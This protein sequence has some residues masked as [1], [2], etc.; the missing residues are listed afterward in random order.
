VTIAVVSDAPRSALVGRAR[1]RE[2]IAGALE[3]LPARPGAIV[4]IE[5]EPGI[6]KSR[7]LDHLTARAAADGATVL[8]ARASEFEGD[9]PYALWTEALDRHL[10][11]AGE[12][13]VSRMGLADPGALAALLPA[14]A[15][16]GAAQPAPGDRH[17]AHRAL[18]DLLERLAAVRPLVVWMDDVHWA[19]PASLDALAALVR[20]PPAAPVLFAV[21]A[22]E[23]QIPAGLALALAG[24]YREERVIAL[25]LAPLNETEAAELVGEAAAAIFPHSGGNPFYLEQLARV[26]DAPRVAAG[27]ADDTVPPAVAAAL[28]AELAELSPQ[29]RR[30]LDAAAVAGDPFEPELAA[31]VAELP[32]PAA[33]HALDELLVGALVRPAGV[34]RR[35]AFRHPVVRHAVYVATPPGW[36]LGAHARAAEVLERR[37]AGPVQRAHHVEHA[38]RPGDDD[39]IALLSTAATE[40]QS[41]APRTAARFHAAALRLLGDHPGQ[42]ERRSR[43]QR[44]LADAQ[45]AGGDPVAARRTL[46]DALQ[47]AGPGERLALTV[48]LANQEWWLGGHE[49]AR[50]RLQV[51]LGELPAQASPDRVRLR[52]ALALTALL[53]CELDE[54]Q[55]QASDARADARAIGDPVFE[56]AALA[57]G[58]LASTS[59]ADGPEAARHLEESAAALER[60]TAA[61]LAT[62]LPAF[63]MHGRARRALGQL[64][65]A[66]GDLRRGAAIAEQTGRE[67]VLLVLTVESVATLIDLGRLA[68]ATAA[69]DEGIERARLA[70]NP[71]TLLWA[72]SALASA[73]LAAGDV[74][75]ALRHG[76]QAAQEDTRPDFYA[77]GQPGWCLGAALTAAGNP[78][79]A[80]RVMLDAFGGHEL[81]RVLPADRPAAAADLIEAQL[82][83]GDIAAA[84]AALARADAV[85]TRAGTLPAIAVTGI[86]RAAVLL[87]RGRP[88]EAV[89]AAVAAREA[90]A[91]APLMSA[92]ALLAEGQARAAAGDRRA[93]VRALAAAEAALDGFGALR[94]RD[95]AAREL[96]RLGHRVLRPARTADEGPLTGR[97]REIAELV[98]AG[99]TNREAAEQ[100][101]LSTRTIEAHLRNIYGKLDVRS[102]VELAHALR[103]TT[104]SDQSTSP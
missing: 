62:R 67:R 74:A 89:P 100:L 47:T 81:A 53:A 3:A 18:R 16:V 22:R 41:P 76:E 96:R 71:R 51:A 9:L 65:A 55:A 1:E 69:A 26:R 29:A 20:R 68:E 25:R 56:L 82:A 44:V 90:A 37:G 88:Q 60:L 31:A 72:Q 12:R 63:W 46:L 87:A 21:T 17:R 70:G 38:A 33:L 80:V 6:G 34:P 30:V 11:D 39:A 43:L 78:D 102:R 73:R 13:R 66:L 58:A 27:R 101:V 49:D 36:R 54:A 7:L 61:Q 10:S 91:E 28:A 48:A 79:R 97:E 19:D 94:R 35:F 85:A 59:A 86:A 52:L 32:E 8:G 45:A 14:L 83:L 50:R 23:G 98:A 15:G 103:R 64:E 2:A 92:R 77:A 104:D 5:G 40:L 93:A 42:Q 57:G 75:A 24:A 95:E 99:R 4:A 84:E